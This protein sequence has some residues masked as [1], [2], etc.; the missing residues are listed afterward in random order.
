MHP[1]VSRA[2]P[3]W[4]HALEDIIRLPLHAGAM[5]K[6][7]LPPSASSGGDVGHSS[8]ACGFSGIVMYAR[9]QTR[10][11]AVAVESCPL[12][13]CHASAA[14]ESDLGTKH[15]KS[16]KAYRWLDSAPDEN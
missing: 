13:V 1:K 2:R 11:P 4:S 8:E 3:D 10:D 7:T 14:S 6:S 9:S 5:G 12:E 15:L 16:W